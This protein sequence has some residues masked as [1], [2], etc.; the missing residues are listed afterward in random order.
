MWSSRAFDQIYGKSS[1]L[2]VLTKLL[3]TSMC[4]K[5]AAKA[6]Q[7]S[8]TYV[9]K[10][11]RPYSAELPSGY[12][13]GP[14]NQFE[15]LGPLRY[16][17]TNGIPAELRH[18]IWGRLDSIY[19]RYGSSN[20]RSLEALSGDSH[21]RASSGSGADMRPRQGPYA[22][23]VLALFDPGSFFPKTAIKP[24][25]T[26]ILLADDPYNLTTNFTASH[27]AK[28]VTYSPDPYNAHDGLMYANTWLSLFVR[29]TYYAECSPRSRK[30]K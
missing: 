30:H 20:I 24:P 26:P 4:Y 14:L 6:A 3:A 21:I 16:C 13:I 1:Y 23:T 27:P 5:N 7:Y 22:M 2:T 19:L 29:C 12:Q 18:D 10:L 25:H 9:S 15:Q 28:A 17:S 8:E 11:I